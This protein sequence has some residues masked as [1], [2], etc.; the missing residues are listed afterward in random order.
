[1]D[2]LLASTT[3]LNFASAIKVAMASWVFLPQITAL[4]NSLNLKRK[5]N[6]PS[7]FSIIPPISIRKTQ[8]IKDLC[9]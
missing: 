7:L 6:P 5:L 2:S 1:M 8:E 4:D 9:L 3:Q